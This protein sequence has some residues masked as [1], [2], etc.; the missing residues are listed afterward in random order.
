MQGKTPIP[1][2]AIPD[3]AATMLLHPSRHAGGGRERQ[4]RSL[5][6]T[7]PA[8]VSLPTHKGAPAKSQA[9]NDASSASHLP[10]RRADRDTHPRQQATPS[11]ATL[12]VPAVGA[13]GGERRDAPVRP[14]AQSHGTE[15]RR[16][17][18]APPCAKHSQGG[19]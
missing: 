16:T 17:R 2:I 4:R 8:I 14:R 6:R 19:Q 11:R 10:R 7:N 12:A 5:Q 3:S 18:I 9:F 13:A 15:R 1:L